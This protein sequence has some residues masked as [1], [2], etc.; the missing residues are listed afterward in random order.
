[1]SIPLSPELTR[2][3]R[4]KGLRDLNTLAAG[5][6][7]NG[8]QNFEAAPN[9]VLSTLGRDYT[10]WVIVAN[11][12]NQVR[13]KATVTVK[14]PGPTMRQG[15]NATW[16]AGSLIAAGIGQGKVDDSGIW[17]STSKVKQ[18]GNVKY[19]FFAQ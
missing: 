18:G 1:M 10:F 14:G 15:G 5:H 19:K 3:L 7:R 6:S 11:F 9:A 17:Q 2:E 4:E 8:V 16:D 13:K 12:G